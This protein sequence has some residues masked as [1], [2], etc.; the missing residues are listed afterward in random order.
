MTQLSPSRPASCVTCNCAPE[1]I[2]NITEQGDKEPRWCCARCDAVW[3]E[4]PGTGK[5][6][7]LA[8]GWV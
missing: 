5:V 6:Q 4:A 3:I 2:V 7:I 8:E 1:D